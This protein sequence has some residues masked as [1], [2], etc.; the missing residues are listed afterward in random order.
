[1]I[2]EYPPRPD[3]LSFNS[4]SIPDILTGVSQWVAWHY[5]FDTD[6]ND[7]TKIP[8][9]VM[10]GQFAKSTDPNT[11]ASFDKALEYHHRNDT[12]TDG[13]GIVLSD[14][15][16]LV[17]MDLD[18]CRDPEN[19]DIEAWAANLLDSVN[20]YAEVSPSGTGLRLFGCGI[21]PDGGNRANIDGADGHLEMYADSRYLTV[22]GHSINGTPEDVRQVNNAITNV[23]A[24]LIVGDE[25]IG[26]EP[27]ELANRAVDVN[28]DTFERVSTRKAAIPDDELIRK[29]KNAKNSEKFTNLWTGSTAGYESHS[30]ADLALCGLL[31]FWTGGKKEQIDRL[32]RRSELMRDKWDADR[33]NQTYGERTIV[34]ALEGRSEF[35]DSSSKRS[36]DDSQEIDSPCPLLTPNEVETVAGLGEDGSIADLNDRQKAACVWHLITESDNIHI[37]VRRDNS[38]I[39]AYDVDR[40]I[41]I[42]DGK[43]ILRQAAWQALG[44]M[45]YGKNVFHEL[46]AQA[47]ADSHAELDADEFGVSTG[48]IAVANGLLDLE[49]AA[50]GAGTDAIRD[51]SPEDYALVRLPVE[52][53]PSRDYDKWANYVDE[54]T[55]DGYDDA[56]Q[57]Y[58]GYCLHVGEIPIHRALLLVGSGANGKGTFLSVVRELLGPNNTTS[59]ELQTLANE[60]DAVADFYGSL[61]NID[62][63]LSA[64][65][66]GAGLGV[67]KKIVAGD[68]VRA[69]RLYESSFE[70]D[71]VG[72]HLYAANEVPDVNVPDDDEAFWRRW[73]L[74]EFPNHYPLGER[75][76][77]LRD[78]LTDPDVLSGVLN[79]A[80]D[81][82]ARLLDQ[83]YFTN[84]ETYA[85][86]KRER[87][88]AWGDSV[89]KFISE[90]IK[91]D[92][93]AENVSTSDVHRV[94]AAWCRKNKERPTS[95]QKLTTEL[96]NEDLDYAKS[97]R[98]GGIGTPTRGYKSLGYTDAAPNLDDTPDRS[99][100]QQ[101]LE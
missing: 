66:L 55:E 98:P 70:F 71:A 42:P 74:V 89:D 101:S 77:E 20:T 96:K 31:A 94:Y 23:H 68:R 93:D 88:Q 17:G 49:L 72:K 61:A 62:D 28:S 50:E 87:W 86:A 78:R 26:E 27:E 10:T 12:D 100:G 9:N 52:Y 45:N 65:K 22:T 13:L 83:D 60:R 73:I 38:S 35:Y 53:D 58:I 24:D 90:C 19:G 1:M 8:I 48:T 97:V 40:G 39:W 6:R 81:G 41:W 47:R 44:A 5:K 99:V 82:R 63:D 4:E 25:G 51:I 37:R 15:D 46:E 32:F 57:E 18:D 95:Q 54:W 33:G 36:V 85:Q 80:I 56:L 11:W 14:D 84:E 34:K 91:R 92:P 75:D 64:R 7:W 2:N 16:L 29:A 67:F 21:L 69:R 59:I 43:R 3:A 79:W 76:P 30:E